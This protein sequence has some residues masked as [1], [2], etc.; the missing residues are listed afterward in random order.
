MRY[1]QIDRFNE[2]VWEIK[3]SRMLT[4]LVRG[5]KTRLLLDPEGY[6]KGLHR[7]RE[8]IMRVI[9]ADNGKAMIIDVNDK[10]TMKNL[11]KRRRQKVIEFIRLFNRTFH[12]QGIV[13]TLL[14]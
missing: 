14:I 10:L 12:T 1:L 2:K 13:A 3:R 4:A 6:H 5:F 11:M 9:N 7:V 8:D